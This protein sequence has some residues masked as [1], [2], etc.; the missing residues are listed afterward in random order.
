MAGVLFAFL[1]STVIVLIRMRMPE[2]IGDSA[3]WLADQWGGILTA[4]ALMPLAGISFL[5]FIAVVR[6][7]FG[8]YEDRFF[9]SVFVGSGFL[10]LAMMFFATAV[11][12]GL[13]ASNAAVT[14]EVAHAEIVEFGK[15]VVLAASKT[16]ALRMAAVFMIS[17]ATIWVKTGLMP[18]W[19]VM[20]SYLAALTL[21]LISDVSLWITLVFP[22]WVLMVS[23]LILAR[24]G[25][26]DQIRNAAD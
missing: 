8:R 24:S 11:A 19:L 14:S 22:V 18:R 3:G 1:F 12:A 16:Y 25:L 10:F 4:T 20:I 9:S 7:G 6:D 5:W 17:L 21:L 13:L 15:M 23:V 2:G 26:I